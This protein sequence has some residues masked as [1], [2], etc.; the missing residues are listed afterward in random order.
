MRRDV[1]VGM[2]SLVHDARYAC[3]L[4]GRAPG[5]TVTAIAT[6]ALAIGANAAI[7]SA[8]KGILI[9]PL[10][11]PGADRLVRLFEEAPRTPRFPFAPADFRDYRAELRTF[12]GLAA[13]MRA[14]LQLGDE[15]RPEQLRGMQATAGFFRVLGYQPA[16]GRDFAPED[17][18]AGGVVIFSHGLWMR[19]FNGDAAILEAP[20]RLS[21]RTFR[22]IGVLPPGVQHVGGTYRTY[23]H[24]EHVDVWWPLPVPRDDAPRHRFSHYFNVVG[25]TRAGVSPSLA[26]ADVKAAGESAAKRYP[27]PNSPWT[28]RLVPLKDEIVGSAAATLWALSAAAAVVLALACVNVAGLLLGRG[29]ARS[30]EIGVR[31]ALGATGWRLVRQLLIESLVLAAAGGAVGAG[32]AYAFV[33]ALA[34]YG[35]ADLPR[36]QMITVDGGVLAYAMAAT[37]L[38][39]LVFGL[40]PALQLARTGA[41]DSLKQGARSVAGGA[42]QRA[43]RAL[44]AVQV[45]LAFLLI[46]S[47]ALLLRG[48]V[49]ML[50]TDPGFS[51][52]GAMTASLELPTAR[53]PDTADARAFFA[54]AQASLSAQPGVSRVAFGSDLPWTGYDENT[55]FEIVG[56]RFPAGEGP[57]GRYHYITPGY[58]DAVGTRLIA[59]RDFTAADASAAPAVVLVNESLARRHWDTPAAAVGAR[60]QLWGAERTVAGVIGD[61]RDMPW[62][63]STVPALYFPLAQQWFPQRMFLVIRTP[64]DPAATVEPARRVIGGLDPSLPLADIKPLDSVAGAALAARRLTLWLVGAFG[65]TALLLAMV[66]TYG[67]MAQAVGQRR[68]EFGIRQALGASR[69]DIVRLVLTSGAT[70]AV[71]GVAA[72]LLMSLLVIPR[73]ATLL[74]GVEPEDPPTFAVVSLL[75]L[76]TCLAA[77]YLP[78]RRAIRLNLSSVLRD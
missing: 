67:V 53:Y 3:R 30:R 27:S 48:F 1:R 73:F 24:G 28:P 38:S 11:Y 56:R 6:L 44:A 40:A 4:L 33:A 51:P 8:V 78:A 12:D 66:G 14:D 10:P 57:A 65:L 35:P 63:E 58:A 59:G 49:T 17:E 52:A 36:L 45:A 19:R 41:G 13:Y 62:H 34:R 32:L 77:A 50:T 71:A 23:G 60:L 74:S 64:L 39:A 22:V 26:E 75:L 20:V 68:Q 61:V 16:L 54:R 70:L 25:R 47:S 29:A 5:F 72:G 18:V 31:S 2:Q 9:A 42:H 43:R 7:F 69:T 46:M 21:G 55:S 37:V 15:S 76:T